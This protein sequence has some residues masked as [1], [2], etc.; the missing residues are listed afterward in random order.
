[1]KQIPVGL[2]P[3]GSERA[4]SVGEYRLSTTI[5]VFVVRIVLTYVKETTGMRTRRTTIYTGVPGGMCW[6]KRV[7]HILKYVDTIQNSYVQSWTVTA[8]IA[9]EKRSL[10]AVPR[11]VPVG[12][13]VLPKFVRWRSTLGVSGIV[14]PS[15]YV[16][17]RHQPCYLRACH[18]CVLY[19]AWD[20]KDDY[21]VACDFLQSNLMAS[22]HELL[23]CYAHT[24]TTHSCQFWYVFGN[25]C[26][27]LVKVSHLCGHYLHNSTL[28]M[29]VSGYIGIL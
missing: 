22:C 24:E 21:G 5:F 17:L 11:S 16:A 18:S 2:A 8:I 3:R 14:L 12:W 28:D 7:F 15:V 10:P 6:T 1:M 23:W 29:A 4:T 27:T 19:S 25:K 26:V 13:L 20:P 9:K